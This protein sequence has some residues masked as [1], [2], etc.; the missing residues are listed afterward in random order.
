MPREPNLTNGWTSE[1][2]RSSGKAHVMNTRCFPVVVTAATLAVGICF[3]ASIAAQEPGTP[4]VAPSISAPV[5]ETV[6]LST[7]A[8]EILKLSRAKINDEVT[9]A[10]VQNSDRRY[11]L[12]ASEIVY[13]RK[14]GVSERVL[15]AMLNEPQTTVD[16]QSPPQPEAMATAAEASA[17]QYVAPPATT[18][19]LETAPASTVYVVPSTPTY[20]SFYDPWPYWYDPWPYYYYPT[21]AFGFYWGSY[22]SGCHNSYWN[23]YCH[24]DNR[25]PPPHHGN[26]PRPH[27][28]QNSPDRNPPPRGGDSGRGGQ[29]GTLATSG[30]P[31]AG[32]NQAASNTGS[33]PVASR[34]AGTAPIGRPTSVSNTDGN[35][36]NA[37]RPSGGQVNAASSGSR[38][39]AS[40]TRSQGIGTINRTPPTRPTGIQTG[41]Q[42]AQGTRSSSPT[43]VWSSKTSQTTVSRPRVSQPAATVARTS[44]I[45]ASPTT[46]STRTV[47]ASASRPTV[48]YQQSTVRPSPSYRTTG[49]AASIRPSSTYRSVGN[50]SSVGRPSYGGGG[51]AASFSRP[52]STSSVRSMGSQG[53]FRGGGSYSGGGARMSSGGGSRGG[54][55]GGRSR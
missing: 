1:R 29:P 50:A 23:N 47:S 48:G 31:T 11:S 45:S 36:P 55:G 10:F 49:S 42:T 3:A 2:F 28:N 26:R 15:V 51:S 19:F 18:T 14:E 39:V 27:G 21:F 7:G 24:Y 34:N 9:V 8:E 37:S 30:R 38:P 32:V 41:T 4:G 52:S 44:R 46:G 17:P 40:A 5:A 13:L 22:W 54:G 53:S 16:P 20:Y 12:N 35:R 25:P 6:P 43:S 33:R